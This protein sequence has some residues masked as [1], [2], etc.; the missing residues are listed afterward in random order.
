MQ[1]QKSPDAGAIQKGLNNE[2]QEINL[3]LIV[4]ILLMTEISWNHLNFLLF[5][6]FY[7]LRLTIEIWIWETNLAR[8]RVG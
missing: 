2:N 5:F 4:Y 7:V 8:G 1:D 6:Y 3:S